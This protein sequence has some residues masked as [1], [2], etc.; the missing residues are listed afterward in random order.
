MKIVNRR[1]FRNYKEIEVYE[2]GIALTGAEVKSVRQGKIKLDESFIKIMEDG[3]IYLINAQI[4]PYRYSQEKNYD[5]KRKRRLLLHKKE[6]VRLLT[7]IKSNGLTI[8][9][10]SCYNKGN[11]IKIE[12]AL[13]KGRKDIEKRKLEKKRDIEKEEEKKLKE[14]LRK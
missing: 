9:P 6:I 8:A 13:V 12:I 5:P 3:N 1:F 14:Y 10:K 2:A 4:F 7:K 11:K